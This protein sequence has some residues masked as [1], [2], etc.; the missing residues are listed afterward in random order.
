MSGEPLRQVERPL[1]PVLGRAPLLALG[2]LALVALTLGGLWLA[3]AFSPGSTGPWSRL[4]FWILEQQNHFHRALTGELGALRGRQGPSA[5]L[6]SGALVGLAFLY[7]V[8]HAAGPGHGKAVIA[9]Y[10]LTQGQA[11][12]R[13]IALA[14]ASAF[15]QGLVALLLVYGLIGLA[16]W[17]P[18]ESGVAVAWSERLS[19]LLVAG[20]GLLLLLRALRALWRRAS[21]GGTGHAAGHAHHQRHDHGHEGCEACA[22]GPSAEQIARAGDWR[23]SLAILLSVGLRPCSGAVV[24]LVFARAVGLGW[25]GV[26]AVAAVSLGTAITVS[27]LAWLAVHA[28][29]LASRVA[30][31]SERL[32]RS[33]LML[34]GEAAGL[35]GGLVI[36]ALGLSLLDSSFAPAHPLGLR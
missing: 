2:A 8:F 6:A 24:I 4:V 14:V 5:L 12:R 22:H 15:C 23:A 16:G 9:T 17:L 19:Y 7:G 36:L 13:G 18:R 28:R 11:M 27:A 29:E 32:G 20:V 21:S 10:L 33:R 35:A 25:A 26:A 31:R 1:V 3:G 30:E 34:L